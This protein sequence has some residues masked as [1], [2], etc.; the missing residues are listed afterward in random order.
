MKNSLVAAALTAVLL[1]SSS[2]TVRAMEITLGAVMDAYVDESSPALTSGDEEVLRISADWSRP[3]DLRQQIILIKFDL[4]T[5][6]NP[7]VIV[8]KAL[9]R[10][11]LIEGPPEPGKLEVSRI[12]GSWDENTARW[13]TKPLANRD[14]VAVA[15]LPLSGVF[16]VDVSSLVESWISGTFPN[17]GFYI[18]ARDNGL[19]VR[20]VFGSKDNKDASLLPSLVINPDLPD[21]TTGD[22]GNLNR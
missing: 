6:N 19:L 11:H 20:A 8:K 1:S 15:M 12:A 17:N 21:S 18:L 22:V 10:L 14:T 5:L 4:D 3:H 7:P 9:L 2:S 16:E 13:L